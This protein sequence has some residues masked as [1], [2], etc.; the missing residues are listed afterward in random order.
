MSR[1]AKKD[2]RLVQLSALFEASFQAAQA[3]HIAASTQVATLEQAI[4]DLRDRHALLG[5]TAKFDAA[6]VLS[7]GRHKAWIMQKIKALNLELARAMVVEDECREALAQE[8][9]RKQV[10]SKL[11]E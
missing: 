9:G 2:P 10:L 7:A 3:A 5:Q 8:N 11:V 6:D 4:A 1:M